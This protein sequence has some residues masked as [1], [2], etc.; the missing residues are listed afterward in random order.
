MVEQT[1]PVNAHY[2]GGFRC[3]FAKLAMKARFAATQE[4]KLD[5]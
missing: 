2:S 5:C 4:W 1:I 3:V